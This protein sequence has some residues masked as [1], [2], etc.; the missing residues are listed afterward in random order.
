MKAITLGTWR[1]EVAVGKTP[2]GVVLSKQVH[3]RR[4][5]TAES[6][7][8]TDREADGIEMKKN[9]PAA[10]I[11]TADCLP[12]V[13]AGETTALAL[14]V[15]RKSVVA[16]LL[17]E[18]AINLPENIQ[19]AYLGPYICA[20]HLIMEWL[21]D[22][23]HELIR[24]WPEAVIKNQAWHIS[25]EKIVRQYLT[26]WG[27]PEDKIQKDGRCTYETLELASRKRL[28]SAPLQSHIF[29]IVRS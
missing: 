19:G 13:I 12:L 18:A 27:V 20:K 26:E 21:G 23:V 28:G 7:Q 3:G 1:V 16:G 8:H 15:S 17:D 2:Q 25:L 22:E 5:A 24:R 4:I 6:L 10:A 9:S 29:T 11:Y 14:H